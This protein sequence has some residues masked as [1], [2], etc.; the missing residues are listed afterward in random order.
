LK[1]SGFYAS[2][3]SIAGAAMKSNK[4]RK[5]EIRI[6]RQK[7]TAKSIERSSQSAQIVQPAGTAPCQ[8]ELLA[9]YNSYGT[10]RFVER[11]YYTDTPFVCRDCGKQE[12]WKATQQK[13]W[14]EVAKGNVESRAIRCRSCRRKEQERKAE[15]R[16]QQLKGMASR[17]ATSNRSPR[18]KTATC[19]ADIPLP[20]N[21]VVPVLP[22]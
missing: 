7:R 19:Q 22:S 6:K 8:P 12:L 5:T 14:Y 1:K 17:P 15:A 9:S 13:W 2:Y 18:I 3:C 21:P 16:R 11:G 10:P 20:V 4:Q